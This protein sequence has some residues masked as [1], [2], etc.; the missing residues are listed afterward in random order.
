MRR[1]PR[2]VVWSCFHTHFALTNAALDFTTL[3]G[4]A[5]HYAAMMELIELCRDQ[6]ALDRSRSPLRSARA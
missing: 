6:L 2:D 3:A 5:R 1:D 4:T